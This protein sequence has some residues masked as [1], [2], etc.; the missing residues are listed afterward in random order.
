MVI[1]NA[2]R[3]GIKPEGNEST[4]DVPPP[5]K[6]FNLLDYDSD[7]EKQG[8]FTTSTD[9]TVA[10]VA[11]DDKTSKT[12]KSRDKSSSSS[13]AKPIVPTADTRFSY[14][15]FKNEQY[16]HVAASKEKA[17]VELVDTIIEIPVGKRAK[18]QSEFIQYL[19]ECGKVVEEEVDFV[20]AGTAG[21]S[22]IEERWKNCSH[23][24]RSVSGTWAYDSDAVQEM[25]FP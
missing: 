22:E 10:F 9:D 15:P 20:S 16:G 19:I 13:S 21:P 7:E 5:P 2:Q 25:W 1:R 8:D 12:A 23:D 4:L 6:P 17:H 18:Y 24:F 3:K 11:T 14:G